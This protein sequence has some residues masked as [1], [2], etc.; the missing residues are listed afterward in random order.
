MRSTPGSMT[1]PDEEVE[2]LRAVLARLASPERFTKKGEVLAE[3]HAR[4][5]YAR[6]MI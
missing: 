1:S 3:L 6:K 5:E 2:R 4:I